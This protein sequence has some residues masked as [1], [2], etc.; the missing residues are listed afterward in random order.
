[1]VVFNA[2]AIQHISAQ[3]R[4]SRTDQEIRLRINWA[5]PDAMLA[6]EIRQLDRRNAKRLDEI[7]DAHGWPGKSL[8]GED[9]A[10]AA[11][12]IAQHAV[13]DRAL[14]KWFL[15]T[16]VSESNLDTQSHLGGHVEHFQNARSSEPSG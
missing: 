5:D 10:H 9:G 8:V 6:E 14:I 15:A 2:A 1:M 4:S 7:V 16:E 13:H 3:S 11:W 12:L